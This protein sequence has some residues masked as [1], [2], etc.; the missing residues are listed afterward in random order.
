MPQHSSDASQPKR[1]SR[2][3]PISRRT[4]LKLAAAGLANAFVQSGSVAE[5]GRFLQNRRA[6]R[7]RR[8]SY[9]TPAKLRAIANYRQS[10]A[11]YGGQ[12]SNAVDLLLQSQ[13][14]DAPYELDIAIIGSGYGGAICGARLAQQMMPNVRLAV[15]ERGRE[16]VPGTFPDTLRD[17]L[18]EFRMGVRPSRRGQI[19]RP[20][21]LIN[22]IHN[23]EV[24][25][26]S[27]NAL[28]GTSILNANVVMKPERDVFRQTNWPFALRDRDVLE[29]FYDAFALELGVTPGE[30]FDASPRRIALRRAASRMAISQGNFHAA[31]LSVTLDPRRLDAHGRNRQGMAQAA[32]QKCGDCMAGCNFGAKNT[33]AM[34]YLPLAKSHGAEIYTRVET[35]YIEKNDGYYRLHMVWHRPGGGHPMPFTTTARVVILAGGSIGSSE[36]LLRSRDH[37]LPLSPTLGRHWSANGDAVGFVAGTSRNVHTA[38]TG[39]YETGGPTSGPAIQ[40]VFNFDGDV[41]GR[42]VVEDVGVPRAFANLFGLAARN[43]SLDDVLILLG[44][45]RDDAQ[46]RIVLQNGLPRV[47]WPRAN[48]QRYLRTVRQKFAHVAAAVGGQYRPFKFLKGKLVTAHPLGG[49]NMADDPRYGVTNDLGKVFDG[50][51]SGRDGDDGQAMFH[52][53]LYVA[54]GSVVPGSL[55]ANPFYTIGAL[56][57]RIAAGIAMESQFQDLFSG[58]AVG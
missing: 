19:M 34:T 12:L 20:S 23:G 17:G 25:V 37:G 13:R 47:V 39:T 30:A 24:N 57:E 42:M 32:C 44:M 18:R 26:I 35:R 27:A 54:D 28:G 49:C 40:D 52:A 29:P 7:S 9:V 21:G 4:T 43:A 5:A 50:S 51:E 55:I 8:R 14:T 11:K 46:G 1:P 3:Q 53:G 16:W 22:Y 15:L 2:S 38:G 36:I 58:H 6:A 31:N 10:L 56:A 48:N 33:L 45:A 41:N